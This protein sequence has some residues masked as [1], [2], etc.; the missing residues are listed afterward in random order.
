MSSSGLDTLLP[1]PGAVVVEDGPS[2]PLDQAT[3]DAAVAAASAALAAVDAEDPA[4]APRPEDVRGRGRSTVRIGPAQAN[5]SVRIDVVD[6]AGLRRASQVLS[7]LRTD[8]RAIPPMT[9]TDAPTLA[10][11]GVVEGF[12]GPPWSHRERLDFFAFALQVGFTEYVYA[13]KDD[14]HHRERWREPYPPDELARIGELARVAAAHGVVFTYAVSPAL[15]MCFVDDADHRALARKCEQV[16]S[17]GVT[18][19]ALLFDDVPSTLQHEADR[20]HHGTDERAT[21]R[22]HGAAAARFVTDFL[23]PAGIP[24]PLLVCPT[25]YAGTAESPYRDGF[26]ET[27]PI[28]AEVLWTGP[29]I[30]VGSISRAD[31]DA[32]ATSYRRRLVLW[33]N[34]PVNDFDR[35]RLFLGPLRGRP[36]D[37][38]GSAL[39]GICA[40]PMVEAVPSRLALATVADWAWDPAGY[41]PDDAA[42]RALHLVAGPDADTVAALV[43]ACSAW[44][45][46]AP[47]SATLDGLCSAAL[48]GDAVATDRLRS[49]LTALVDDA[50]ASPSTPGARATP[51]RTALEPW[52]AAARDTARAGLLACDLVAECHAHRAS[53]ADRRLVADALARSED[54]FPNVLRGVVPPFVRA[55][56]ARAG[57]KDVPGPTTRD[58]VLVVGANPRPGDRDLAERLTARGNAVHLTSTPEDDAERVASADL[59]IV[60]DGATAQAARFLAHAAV[61]MLAWARLQTL[62]LT[63][64]SQ[65]AL[66]REHVQ[67]VDAEHPLAAG[68]SGTVRVHRGPGKVTW[69][70]PVPGADVVARTAEEHEAVIA[71]HS[72]GLPLVDGVRAPADRVL[73]FLSDDGLA[74][75]LLAPGGLALFDAAVDL[76]LTRHLT[77]PPER[78]TPADHSS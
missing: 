63:D 12:Y 54:H 6:A 18:S 22:A 17:A 71:L 61:P 77:L 11:R 19:F 68:A 25:D 3:C 34:F 75:W 23:G 8:G 13:P 14:L 66:A 78:R 5:R 51:L 57:A 76:L 67:V 16:R 52:T 65:V 42:R 27:L 15:S 49:A 33:D 45:P 38:A 43:D 44:P 31:V 7:A 24:G 39:V 20:R 74:P 29:D 37:L 9:V 26:A 56:L 72:A 53:G 69:T 59:V 50:R 47:Q 70:R 73:F 4:S 60:G 55:V 10:R 36:S 32:A 28:D 48:E 41:D 64:R 1:R 40:N 46:S 58:V 62:A 35:S 21:G 30:V 2:G